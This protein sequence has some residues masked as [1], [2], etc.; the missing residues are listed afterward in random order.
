M[1]SSSPKKHPTTPRST[2]TPAERRQ[3]AWW[4]VG[5]LLLSGLCSSNLWSA[6]PGRTLHPAQRKLTPLATLPTL[7]RPAPTH[8][9][10]QKSAAPNSAPVAGANGA[11][12]S[13]PASGAPAVGSP[14]RSSAVGVASTGG[15]FVPPPPA[16]ELPATPAPPASFTPNPVA[17]PAPRAATVPN[18]GRLVTDN[19]SPDSATPRG[20]RANREG[21]ASQYP[22]KAPAADARFAGEPGPVQRASIQLVG[23]EE[24]EVTP[25]ELPIRETSAP[26]SLEPT[27]ATDFAGPASE[28]PFKRIQEIFPHYD[29][30]PDTA[31]KRCD[32]LCPRPDGVD[33]PDCRNDPDL[34]LDE[35][36][37]ECPAERRLTEVD[38][39]TSQV[40]ATGRRNFQQVNYC[41]EPSNLYH[42]PIYFE[43][44]CLERYGHTRHHLLQPVVSNGLFAA[45]LLGL[46]YQ[47]TIDPICKKRYVLGWYRPG[48]YVPYTYHQV[49]W[50]T[51]AAIMQGAAVTGGYFLF[52]PAVSP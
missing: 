12:A 1:T 19:G 41:W 5:G 2:S 25:P 10:V 40:A 9:P 16:P 31:A 27:P 24:E 36:C 38:P 46:P 32:N 21:V 49:P 52:A 14:N 28:R 33:C 15:S 50:N 8:V 37:P 30:A 3:P 13:R 45:Q 47:M 4:L 17:T 51:E 39:H 22:P 26:G 35:Q 43:D 42:L 7:Q 18:T 23:A 11:P 20:Y 29:Y 44:F 48:S 34:P 6:P